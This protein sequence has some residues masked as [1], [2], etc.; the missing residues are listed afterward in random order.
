MDTKTIIMIIM[1][2]V[3]AILSYFLV[4]SYTADIEQEIVTKFDTIVELKIDTIFVEKPKIIE[5]K[6]I[7]TLY[8]KSDTTLLCES[9]T[10]VDSVSTIWVS[11]INPL[12]DSVEYHIQKEYITIEKETTITKIKKQKLGYGLHCGLGVGYGATFGNQVLMQPYIGINVS[13]GLNYNF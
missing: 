12:V 10:F 3:I 8:I 9:R 5:R 4:R 11:G 6:V 2:I 1:G 13:F 7:D